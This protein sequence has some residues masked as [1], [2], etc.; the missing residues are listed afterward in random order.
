MTG[1]AGGIGTAVAHRLAD[2]G[3]S[4]VVADRDPVALDRLVD[5][6]PATTVCEA[7]V[8][9]VAEGDHHKSLVEAALDLGGLGLS[10]L[11]AGVVL[12]GL[13]WEVPESQWDLHVKVNL[14]G[15]VHGVRAALPVMVGNDRGHVVAVASGAGLVAAP[16]LSAYTATKHAVVGLMESTHHELARVAP[17]VGVSVVCPGNI[18]TPMTANSLAAAGIE[19][20]QLSPVAEQVATTIR[21]GVDAGAEPSTVADAIVDAVATRRFWVLPQPEVAL[22]ALDRVQRIVDGRP[23]VDLLG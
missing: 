2:D 11:N 7:V 9:D 3:W 23:P 12:P 6:L 18:R 4:L 8:G 19:Q 1:A 13:V 14:W 17:G 16:G 5:E 20:E 22:G 10:V 21:A 15:V